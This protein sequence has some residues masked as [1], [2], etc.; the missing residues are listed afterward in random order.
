MTLHGQIEEAVEG[1]V[2]RWVIVA[3]VVV[4]GDERELHVLSGSGLGNGGPPPWET[5]GMLAYAH[6]MALEDDDE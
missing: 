5:A 1:F 3:E 4:E 2:S 6:K